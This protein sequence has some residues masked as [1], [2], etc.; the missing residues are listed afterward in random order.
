MHDLGDER[1]YSNI[2]IET[3]L[4]FKA[5]VFRAGCVV[6]LDVRGYVKRANALQYECEERGT[7]SEDIC[8]ADAVLVYLMWLVAKTACGSGYKHILE[9]LGFARWFT[10]LTVALLVWP[11]CQLMN[12]ST[13]C[14]SKFWTKHILLDIIGEIHFKTCLETVCVLSTL[15]L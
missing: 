5:P 9:M 15:W 14:G 2:T 7:Q 10:L 1:N 12:F 3:E 4:S 8:E 6:S 13:Y 11:L